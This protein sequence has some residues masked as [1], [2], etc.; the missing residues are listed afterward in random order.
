VIAG[1]FDS[2]SSNR[3]SL[4]ESVELA[5]D[6]SHKIQNS[7]LTSGDSLFAETDEIIVPE[8]K[9]KSA[10]AWSEKES[11]SKER[12]VVGFYISGHPLR[13]YEVEYKSFANFHIGE[14]EENQEIENVRACGV[15]TDIRTKIDK[16]GKQMAFFTIDDFT[17]SCEC[18]MFS[19][20]YSEYGKYVQKEEPVFV[21]GNLESS[22][23]AVKMHVNKL[24]PM[25]IARS[26]L[27]GSIRININKEKVPLQ[28]LYDLQ[29]LLE[30][31][32]GKIP[33]FIQLFTNGNRSSVYA[34]K[35]YR[36]ELT[37]EFFKQLADL[38]GED[39]FLLSA[40]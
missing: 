18:L 5:L 11:L 32:S 36:V 39:S 22:G 13:K 17:G 31:N 28:K 12:E 37:P 1:A 21:I 24:L 7:K 15:I 4:F 16:S 14:A 23:D 27:S 9:L 8:P 2:V 34:L 20:V 6:H 29:S 25:D 40:K 30:N 35:N 10:E 33:V 38:F 3:A 19:K 26:E